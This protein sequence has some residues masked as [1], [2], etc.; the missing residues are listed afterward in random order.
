MYRSVKQILPIIFI[1]LVN[2]G[3]KTLDKSSLNNFKINEINTIGDKRINF[4][5][6]N[7][8]TKFF[9][10][11]NPQELLNINLNIKKEKSI[12]EKNKKNKITKYKIEVVSNFKITFLNKNIS[13]DFTIIEEGYYNVNDNN[14]TNR[15]NQKTLE[16]NLSEKIS[17]KI[18]KNIFYVLDDN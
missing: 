1:L 13:K 14:N 8:I 5:V 10:S 3:F 9:N 16:I 11:D 7:K 15:E 2:C 17:E 6:K 12:K 18:V 4:L